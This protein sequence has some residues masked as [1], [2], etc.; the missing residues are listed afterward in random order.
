MATKKLSDEEKAQPKADRQTKRDEAKKQ[1]QSQGPAAD[2]QTPP[3]ESPQAKDKV[4]PKKLPSIVNTKRY[5]ARE[6]KVDLTDKEINEAGIELAH[7]Q[8]QHARDHGRNEGPHEQLQ[9]PAQRDHDPNE[10]PW[11]T[12]SRSNTNTGSFLAKCG[13]TSRPRNACTKTAK[14]TRSSIPRAWKRM[15][16]S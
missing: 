10:H 6:V 4:K 13:L 11:E 8:K 9:R 3:A 12:R 14:P 7:K 16:T 2:K 1:E 5:A 15:I